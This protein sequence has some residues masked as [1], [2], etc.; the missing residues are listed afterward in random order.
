M[1]NKDMIKHAL[2]S[3]HNIE[4]PGKFQS[5]ISILQHNLSVLDFVVPYH[6]AALLLSKRVSHINRTK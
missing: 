3:G 6:K 5:D 4:S 2:I 1:M